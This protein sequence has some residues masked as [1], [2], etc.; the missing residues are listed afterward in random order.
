MSLQYES[1][2]F[3]D[4]PPRR[5]E[6]RRYRLERVDLQHEMNWHPDASSFVLFSFA[7]AA[8]LFF[9]PR[10]QSLPP[11]NVKGWRPFKTWFSCKE[12]VGTV[13]ARYRLLVRWQP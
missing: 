6:R 10:L 5:L 7:A 4:S 8:P 1:S 11:F 12:W 13:K 2:K 3:W 9:I